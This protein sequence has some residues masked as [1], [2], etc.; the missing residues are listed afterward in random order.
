M[1]LQVI[2]NN[3][4]LKLHS[5]IS[6]CRFIIDKHV[7]LIALPFLWNPIYDSL[8]CHAYIIFFAM[9]LIRMILCR[10]LSNSCRY[11]QSNFCP[12]FIWD[13]WSTTATKSN[14]FCIK[15]NTLQKKKRASLL[16][17]QCNACAVPMSILI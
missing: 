1:F 11:L 6:K 5:F 17:L 16:N 7:N 8:I 3:I 9:W 2:V 4:I 13:N 12:S 15:L 14:L 10:V